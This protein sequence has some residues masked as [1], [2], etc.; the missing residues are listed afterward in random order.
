LECPF[1][2]KQAQIMIMHIAGRVVYISGRVT[3]SKTEFSLTDYSPGAYIMKCRDECHEQS[4][5]VL[6]L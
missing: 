3:G 5:K 6:R 2:E 4:L 1:F